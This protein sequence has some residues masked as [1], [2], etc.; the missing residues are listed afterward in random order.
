MSDTGAS[1]P[2]ILFCISSLSAGGAERVASIMLNHWA[3]RDCDATLL[4]LASHERVHRLPLDLMWDSANLW[5]GIGSNLRRLRMIRATIRDA[6]PDVVVSFIDG[7]NVLVLAALL[8]TGIPVIVSERIDP[9]HHPIRRARRVAR[10]VLYP[11]A[12]AVVVQT[13]AIKAWARGV[14]PERKIR[15]IPNPIDALPEPMDY[16]N[17]EQLVLA[18]GRL[19]WQKGFDLLIEAFAAGRAAGMQWHLAILGEGPERPKLE[20][21]IRKHG[22]QDKVT[23]V[24]NVDDP[25]SWYQRARLF[26]LSSRYEGFPNALLEAMAMGCACIAAECPSGPADIMQHEVNGLLVPP[27]DVGALSSAMDELTSNP[28]DAMQLGSAAARIR[29]TYAL[30]AIMSQWDELVRQAGQA[31]AAS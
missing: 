18:V 4:T 31:P 7:T 3:S 27:E 20:A 25:W 23:L 22:L 30:D 2:R 21:Q 26:V 12:A 1:N 5:A 24:G 15:V 28:A 29:T 14:V 9:R 17:R 13:N 10:R 6:R 19:A 8:G 16:A 11:F